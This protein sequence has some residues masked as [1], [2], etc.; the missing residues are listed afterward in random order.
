M[1]MGLTGRVLIITGA[2]SGV[3]AAITR[4]AVTEAARALVL[5]DRCAAGLDRIATALH[6]AADCAAVRVDLADRTTPPLVAKAAI[7]RFPRIGGLLHAAGLTTRGLAL[8]GAQDV[9]DQL[10]DVSARA[11][12]F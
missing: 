7:A 12:C 6:G 11:G 2:A 10:F 5:V 1:K 8:N 9:W 3:G 4:M